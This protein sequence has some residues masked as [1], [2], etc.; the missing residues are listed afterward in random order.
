MKSL[1]LKVALILIT[2]GMGLLL[3]AATPFQG[4]I[5]CILTAAEPAQVYAQARQTAA[6]QFFEFFFF[7]LALISL[8][9]FPMIIGRNQHRCP[10]TSNPLASKT[11]SASRD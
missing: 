5:I 8:A 7:G 11:V 10:L 9:A 3:I 4:G 6:V 2:I 1:N